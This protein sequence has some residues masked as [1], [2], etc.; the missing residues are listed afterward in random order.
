LSY[1]QIEN[2]KDLEDNVYLD[3]PLM[4]ITK[5]NN[6]TN[7]YLFMALTVTGIGNL[8]IVDNELT[9]V[10]YHKTNRI[11]YDFKLQPVGELTYGIGPDK[12]YAMDSSGSTINQFIAPPGIVLDV[13]ELRVLPDR[14]Y[15]IIGEEHLI[16]DMSQYVQGGDTAAIVTAN[17]VIHMDVDDNEL[18]RWSIFL[19]WMN[20]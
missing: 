19:M 2:N 17:D 9:P 15:Y 14:S 18:W 20:I 12:I 4:E 8:L 13:H 6:P 11:L 10:F 7:D 5:F 1:S 3:Y 16:I